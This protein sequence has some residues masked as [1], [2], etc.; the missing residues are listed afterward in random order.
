M[1]RSGASAVLASTLWRFPL[2]YLVMF[3]VRFLFVLGFAP[4]FRVLRARLTMMEII[5]ATVAGLRGSVS[6]IMAQAVATDQ[7]ARPA[8]NPD[9]GVPAVRSRL[10]LAAMCGTCSAACARSV[11]LIAAQAVAT[12]SAHGLPTMQTQERQQ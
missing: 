4:L 9:T 8:N 2:I 10:E 1:D 3:G 12:A 11:S 5:F 7:R 6:L